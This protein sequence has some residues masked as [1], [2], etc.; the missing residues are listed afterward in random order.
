MRNVADEADR[1]RAD[2]EA[3]E[4]PDSTVVIRCVITVWLV[5]VPPSRL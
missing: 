1:R 3:P 5:T 4:E 2:Q